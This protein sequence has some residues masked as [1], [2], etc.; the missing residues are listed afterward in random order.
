MVDPHLLTLF[1]VTTIPIV[2]FPG[3]SVAFILTNT[4]QKGRTVGLMSM[5]GVETG[6]LVHV[7]GAIVGLSA[8]ITASARLFTIVRL[9]GVAW[10]LWLAWKAFRSRAEGTLANAPQDSQKSHSARAAFRSGLLVGALNPKTAVFFLAFLPQFVSA[11]AG[12]VPLQML[13]FGLLFIALACVP[14][15]LWALAGGYLRR[16]TPKLRLRVLD[17]A[18]GV[19]YCALAAYALTATAR[20][21]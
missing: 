8:I 19:V 11:D 9:A 14:D 3:P 17:R 10:L 15:G 7:F 20:S 5:V 12:S 6:Y 13:V 16:L 18:A 1:L 4:V 2:C 21:S